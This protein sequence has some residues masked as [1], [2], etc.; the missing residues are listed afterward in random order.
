MKRGFRVQAV[1]RHAPGYPG[2]DEAIDVTQLLRGGFRSLFSPW[3]L[4]AAGAIGLLPVSLQRVNA[5]E[6]EPVKLID[7]DLERKVSAVI[8]KYV[9]EVRALNQGEEYTAGV[10]A[11]A[12]FL[13]ANPSIT[14]W[15]AAPD[16]SVERGE[17][18]APV[19]ASLDEESDWHA[20]MRI[21]AKALFELYGVQVSD[22][23]KVSLG[24]GEGGVDFSA[25]GYDEKHRVG[26]EIID[27]DQY[28]LLYQEDPEALSVIKGALLESGE[29]TA[30]NKAIEDGSINMFVVSEGIDPFDTL[31]PAER[32][33]CFM[34]SVVTYLDWLKAEG[35]I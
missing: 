33:R 7:A 27:V 16:T 9:E 26:F 23:T 2:K 5:G 25:D 17:A 20:R 32:L 18:C 12:K 30:L 6:E 4:L 31:D 11:E 35:K 8:A 22:N 28:S 24:E 13:A 1:P 19:P 21:A 14:Y 15:Q 34:E 10:A 29:L 3:T